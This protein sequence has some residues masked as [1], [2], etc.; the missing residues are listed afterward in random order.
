MKNKMINKTIDAL[1]KIPTNQTGCLPKTIFTKIGS[2]LM[3]TCNI[4]TKEGLVNGATGT[5]RHVTTE[6]CTNKIKII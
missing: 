3:I 1:N 6:K 5:L 4:S 2:K